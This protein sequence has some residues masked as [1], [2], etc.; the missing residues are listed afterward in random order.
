MR[1]VAALILLLL[2]VARV[3]A[4]STSSQPPEWQD[5]V[6]L[7]DGFSIN[8]PGQP[9]ISEITWQSQFNYKLPARV[10]SAERGVERLSITVVDYS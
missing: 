1:I 6:S 8:F 3:A 5:Y 7:K 4:Q 9:R 10:Y 2:P